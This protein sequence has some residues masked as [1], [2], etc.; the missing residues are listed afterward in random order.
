M[1]SEAEQRHLF[2]GR[3]FSFCFLK[4]YVKVIGGLFFGVGSIG[5]CRVFE[6]LWGSSIEGFLG[7]AN[8]YL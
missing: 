1:R 4:V 6:G 2:F 7:G 3:V 5:F 8:S